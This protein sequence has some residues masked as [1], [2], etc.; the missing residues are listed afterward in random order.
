MNFLSPSCPAEYLNALMMAS[1]G[2]RGC[3]LGNLVYGGRCEEEEDDDSGVRLAN[4]M[5]MDSLRLAI[6]RNQY[7]D[8][9]LLWCTIVL[10]KR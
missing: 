4:P 6:P 10:K 2:A 7:R 5:T 8:S 9:Y 3:G 1:V